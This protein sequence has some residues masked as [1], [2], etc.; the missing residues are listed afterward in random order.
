MPVD[1]RFTGRPPNLLRKQP[2]SESNSVEE[3]AVAAYPE[4]L[5]GRQQ[6][7]L[8]LLGDGKSNKEIARELDLS[9]N[10]VKIHVAAVLKALAVNNRTKAAVVAR[11]LGMVSER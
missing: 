6:E 5:T 1:R 7:V 8:I 9:E 10:T 4:G 11:Q 3:A 2:L